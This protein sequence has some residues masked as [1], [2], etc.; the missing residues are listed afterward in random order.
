MP[1]KPRL[2]I[3]PQRAM[4]LCA[5]IKE[6]GTYDIEVQWIRSRDYGHN[7]RILFHGD[8]C[9]DVSGCGYDKLSACLA[10]ALNHLAD[11]DADRIAI[12]RTSGAGVSSV[13][14]ALDAA[15]WEM[16]T[17]ASGSD[18]DVFKVSRKVAP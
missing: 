1:R 14:S 6:Y 16:E 11:T 12:G 13:V 3:T 18:H 7:P 10:D 15:G 4:A 17:L 8:K 5:T 9:T 2:P